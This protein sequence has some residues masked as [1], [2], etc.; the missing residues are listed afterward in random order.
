MIRLILVETEGAY[1]AGF[2]ARLCKNF[3]VDELYFVK[4]KFNIEEAYRFSAHGKEI[5]EKAIIIDSYDKALK[6]LDLKIATSSI[7]DNPGD[8][9]RK[10][11]KPWELVDLV[12]EDKRVGLIFG[13]ESVGL[14]REELQ[15]ADFLLF[16]PANPEYPVLNLSHAVSIVLYELWRN[17][18]LK[19]YS[20]KNVTAE[21]Y[22]LLDKYSKILYDLISRS[23]QEISM[24]IALKRTLMRG[25][26]DEEEARTVIRFLRRI[27]TRIT[28]EE[29]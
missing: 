26:S 28:H 14:T 8:I 15:K 29:E 21:A 7:A 9:V 23:P 27:Y 19:T 4:P 5:L 16:I 24:Y 20:T 1:N 22:S 12:T 10:S 11:I 18:A 13:R 17:K 3:K 2:I 25:V 6:D